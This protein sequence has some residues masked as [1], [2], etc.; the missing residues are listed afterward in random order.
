MAG[1]LPGGKS[2]ARMRETG[3]FCGLGE[4][5][6]GIPGG[7]VAWENLFL[8]YREVRSEGDKE[9]RVRQVGGSEVGSGRV[10]EVCQQSSRDAVGVPA[11]PWE[12]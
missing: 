5:V 8:V 12:E 6:F 10:P 9:S 3:R 11:E 2:D 4:F 7:V 1:S